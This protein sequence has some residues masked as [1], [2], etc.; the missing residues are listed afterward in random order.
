MTI[1][2][3]NSAIEEY[4]FGDCRLVLPRREIWRNGEP[5]AAEPKVF[6]L[7]VY[8]VQHRDR[9]VD[10]NELQDEVWSGTIVT[11]ASGHKVHHEGA[12]S[13]R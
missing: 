12:K 1:L 13:D 9:A 5:V 3:R 6:D 8:L 4:R 11:E 2:R 10:K 7:L